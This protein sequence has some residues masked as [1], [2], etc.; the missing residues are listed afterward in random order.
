MTEDTA[1]EETPA[2]A[3]NAIER[4]DWDAPWK[5]PFLDAI[6]SMPNA[7]AAARRAGVS[8]ARIYQARDEDPLFAAAWR[9]ARDVG[10][11][12]LEQIAWQRATV[13]EPRR[14]TRTRVKSVDGKEVEREVVVEETSVISN[15]LLVA[16]LKTFRPDSWREGRAEAG[17]PP[18]PPDVY[19]TP[20]R[21]RMLGLLEL[22]RQHELPRVIEGTAT[23]VPAT[24]A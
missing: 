2:A 9:E 10:L 6:A 7:S 16:L 17:A 1:P 22:A 13:G 11:D 12:L 21:E 18:P 23:V 20:N 15:T 24:E 3:P 4:R 19:R 8:R 14:T 5:A